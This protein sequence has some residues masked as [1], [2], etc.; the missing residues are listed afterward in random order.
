MNRLNTISA[1]AAV[2]GWLAVLLVLLSCSTNPATGKRQLALISEE[3]EIA[4]GR[5]ADQQVQQQLG[6]YNDAEL[7]SYVNRIGQK[8]AAASER[9][10]LQWTFRVVDDPVVN[11]FA[12]PGGHIYVTRGLL[13]HL[14]SEAEL[15][16]VLGHEIGHVTARH[17][18]EQMSKAQLAQI[19]L[20]AGMI[21]KPELAN[22]GDLVNT[23]LQLMFLKFS[24]DDERQADDL[25]LR[26]IYQRNY[27]PR[28]MPQVFETLRRVSAQQGSGRLPGWLATHPTEEARIRT[29]SSEVAKL[30]VSGN[31]IVNREQYVKQLDNVVFGPNPREGYFA[32]NTFIQPDLG[33]QIRFPEGW[34][35][36]NEKASVGAISPSQDAIVVVT[37]SDQRSP[38]AAAQQFFGQQGIQQGQSLRT[39]LGGLPAVARVFGAQTQS[40]EIQG[41]A[42][43]VENAGKVYRILGYTTAQN[44]RRYDD[45]LSSS[46]GSFG[47]V[48]DRQALNVEPKRVDVVSLPS[49]MTLEEF[50][51]RYPS[52]VDTQ[53]IAIINQADPNT[54]FPAGTEVKRVVGGQLPT[55]RGR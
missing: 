24:R 54:R 17:S 13:T 23:G 47:R 55:E 39:D 52:T 28:E 16:S 31:R 14:T 42:A 49:A 36:S 37:L 43:F 26:Y 5:E 33:I 20:I 34:R 50:T 2:V 40:G 9:P 22:Y 35:T 38:Q 3:Q 45:V 10:N 30:D 48:T 25:G 15:A 4:M 1:R 51:R 41:I 46:I 21:V 19:G 7:Q 12:L 27:D 32:G 11:A 44:F 6:L 8:L 29:I 18:V 53:T